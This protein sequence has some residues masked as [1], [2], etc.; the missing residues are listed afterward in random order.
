MPNSGQFHSRLVA[1]LKVVLP[2][3]ALA[4]LSTLF[5]L[6]RQT[7]TEGTLPYADVDVNDLA[8]EQRLAA[9]RFST[10]TADGASISFQARMVRPQ[11]DGAGGPTAEGLTGEIETVDGLKATLAALRG[12]IDTAGGWAD[13]AGD[14]Q[15]ATSTGYT[16]ASQSLRASLDSTQLGSDG[17]VTATA[18]FGRIDAGAMLLRREAGGDVLV[19][20]KGVKLIYDPDS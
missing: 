10:V 19:F 9:P 3:I 6:S 15:V 18:P 5:L 14:V 17:P 8:R 20:D 7:P 1:W 13:L 12:R 2:L 11:G 16:I 4:I